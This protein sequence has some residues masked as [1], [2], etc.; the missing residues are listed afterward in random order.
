MEE[1]KSGNQIL[2]YAITLHI[3]RNKKNLPC[4]VENLRWLWL[5]TTDSD[6]FVFLSLPVKIES[7]NIIS[8]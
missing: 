5:T 1:I 2:F 8:M 4:W 3:K 7:K 6:L